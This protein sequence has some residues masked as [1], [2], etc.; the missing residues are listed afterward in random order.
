MTLTIG[1]GTV[2]LA[3]LVAGV[4][5]IAL[6]IAFGDA[7]GDW[8]PPC[9]NLGCALLAIVLFAVAATLCVVWWIGG[10]A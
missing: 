3:F 1:L 7:G 9:P 6:S 5:A 10:V 2:A 4:V 8:S